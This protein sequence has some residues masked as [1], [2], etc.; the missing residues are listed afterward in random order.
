VRSSPTLPRRVSTDE[1]TRR[2]EQATREAA[3]WIEAVGRFGYAARGVA[4]GLIGLFLVNAAVETQ[5]EEARGLGGALASLAEQPLGPWL[6]GLVALGL[7]AYGVFALVEARY[8]RM[9]VG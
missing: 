2:A 5:P 3:P 9:L 7:T 1:V 8:R 6:L 4:F